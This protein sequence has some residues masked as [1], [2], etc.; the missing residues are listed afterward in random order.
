M[1]S[2]F[3]AD[4]GQT[5]ALVTVALPVHGNVLPVAGVERRA[6]RREPGDELCGDARD[7]GE[8]LED[9]LGRQPAEGERGLAQVAGRRLRVERPEVP[10]VDGDGVAEAEEEEQRAGQ[11][12]PL[13]AAHDDRDRAPLVFTAKFHLRQRQ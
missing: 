6:V 9:P 10:P 13:E 8:Q 4:L 7:R 3:H 5:V 11:G 2:Q 1:R 12:V